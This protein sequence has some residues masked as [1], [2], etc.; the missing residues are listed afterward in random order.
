MYYAKSANECGEWET[1]AHH[2]HSVSELCGEFSIA[3]GCED[4]GLLLGAMHDIGKASQAFQEVLHHQ[5]QGV[6]HAS[7]GA[8]VLNNHP[9]ASW[10]QM[11][12]ADI[13]YAHH[14]KLQY[15]TLRSY[16]VSQMEE[17]F[18][19]S[20]RQFSVQG[21]NGYQEL[22]KWFQ[23]EKW[24][25][26]LM[27]SVVKKPFP[28]PCQ[29]GLQ[30]MLCYRMLY[31]ALVDADWSASAMHDNPDYQKESFGNALDYDTLL[32]KLEQYMTK[33]RTCSAAN[34]HLNLMR[35]QL[36]QDC[37]NASEKES[38]LF[39]LTAPTGSGKTL[40]M[41]RFA[42]GHARANGKKRIIFVLPFLSVIEQ[43]AKIYREICGD[44]LEIH[45]QTYYPEEVR[46]QAER[47]D[48]PIIVTTSVHFF[49]MLFRNEP[50]DCRGLHHFADSVILFDEAQALPVNLTR[51]TIETVNE[52]CEHYCSTIV[53]STATQPA[54]QHV[55]NLKWNP[56]E[57]VTNCAEMFQQTRRTKLEMRLS[58]PTSLFDIAEEMVQLDSVCCIVNRKEHA[59]Q[60]FT[61]LSE[62]SAAECYHI[63]TDMCAAHRLQV[64]AEIR[65]RLK[66]GLPCR[67]VS[68]SCIEAGVDLDF[69][70]M[71]RALAPLE[72]IV[73][74]AGR[75]NRNGTA[76]GKVV[77]F[78]PD[79]E[80]LYPTDWYG[81]AAHQVKI[82]E[83]RHTI[84]IAALSQIEEYY[85]M[86][87]RLGAVENQKLEQAISEMDF[88]EVSKQYQ[89]I[90]NKTSNVLV[91][92]TGKMEL[93]E[94]LRKEAIQKGVS[95][96]WIRRANSCC[97]ASYQR[98][99]VAEICEALYFKI[100]GKNI[101]SGWY[102]LHDTKFYQ[103]KTGFHVE[104]TSALDYLF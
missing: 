40:A 71:Y 49:E 15:H 87:F 20:G 68:T 17:G 89:F 30:R 45:S 32:E 91:P 99:K 37:E 22:A 63:S 75:C 18:D 34:S 102:V 85:Q 66:D 65:E 13:V 12:L 77:V 27:Q 57:I 74:S 103:E 9:N 104:K 60:L 29:K 28:I 38:G 23:Q 8:Y 5:R 83:S 1:L 25:H 46:E 93:Y 3:F 48:A 7:A 31:S 39:T 24:I 84:D 101:A 42:L 64:I 43:N 4:Y 41:L 78:L 35:E 36:Y 33:I 88:T 51:P 16:M 73:Q 11:M 67:V 76:E 98:E 79:E 52:L 96:S 44:V 55:P 2:L 10:H 54:F 21:K 26:S 94:S 58:K 80:K 62:H 14:S 97:V 53:F 50:G 82:M 47:F 81:T 19:E 61:M 56:V 86:L 90:D 100:R 6:N 59:F 72:A 95:A 70:C 69:R 92:Y